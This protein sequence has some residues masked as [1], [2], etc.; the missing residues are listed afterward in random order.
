[1]TPQPAPGLLRRVGSA[2]VGRLGMAVVNFGLFWLLTRRLALDDLGAYSLLM[3]VFLMLQLLPLLGLAAPL[4]RRAATHP[5]DLTAEVTNA[6]AFALPVSAGLA[7]LVALAGLAYPADLRLPFVLV[8]LSV[9]P[10]AWILV[11]ESVLLGRDRMPVITQVQVVEAALRLPLVML[12][13]EGG[14]GLSGAFGVVLALRLLVAVLY[15]RRPEVPRPR[16]AALS[17]ELRAR[18]RRELPVFLGIVLLSAAAQRMDL[19][20]LSR[21]VP[22]DELGVYAAAARLYDAAMMLPTVA[23]L[24]LL[25][26]LARLF[27]SD[28]TR[29]AQALQAA[30]QALLGVGWAIALAAAAFAQPLIDLLYRPDLAASA[31]ALRWLLFAAMLMTLDQ[32]LSSSMLAAEAQRADLITM[33]WTVACLLVAFMLLAPHWGATGAAAALV[34]GVVTRLVGRLHWAGPALGLPQLRARLVRLAL[35]GLPGVAGLVVGLTW[36]AAAA[37]A[38][39][40]AGYAL[41]L[42]VTGCVDAGSWRRWK[43]MRTELAA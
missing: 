4:Q 41:G 25:P 18:N 8:G 6:L 31:V 10:S 30:L 26:R 14:L 20:V 37:L 16:R 29:F 9:L 19:V 12:A 33:A 23:A 38:L 42:V 24:V 35:A 39:A 5:E 22:F 3:N 27:R 7:V 2:F 40:W 21:L 34:A 28:R 15:A 32:L 13:V 43:S 36:G 11:A 1:M 17:A